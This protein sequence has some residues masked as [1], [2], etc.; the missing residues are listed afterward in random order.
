[1]NFLAPAS[2]KKRGRTD[3]AS[4]AVAVASEQ[5]MQEVVVASSNESF[6]RDAAS[7][8][9]GR[10]PDSLVLSQDQNVAMAGAPEEDKAADQ[11]ENS[12]P[13]IIQNAEDL[14][15]DQSEYQSKA[16]AGQ[17]TGAAASSSTYRMPT[18]KN[19]DRN[20]LMKNA[21]LDSR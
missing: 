1:M 6:L 3:A 12:H 20:R 5:L 9:S 13:N 21:V 16:K 15:A 7:R 11:N 18:R 2:S 17:V 8:S 14:P 4:A 10:V 19:R